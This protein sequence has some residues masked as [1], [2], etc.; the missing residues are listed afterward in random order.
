M[1]YIPFL[2]ICRNM[3]DELKQ[4][5]LN[6]KTLSDLAE[7]LDV[8]TGH[9][10]YW[11]N[12]QK[13][14][15][16]YTKF[17]IPKK[18]GKYRTI[19][20]PKKSLKLLQKKLNNI[21]MLF[22]DVKKPVHG[23]VKNKSIITNANYHLNK[24]LVLNLDLENFFPTINKGRVFGIFRNKPFEFSILVSK[25]LS[26]I[27]CLQNITPQGAPTSPIISNFVC[28]KLDNDLTQLAKAF[29]C[30]YSR[31]ADDITFSTNQKEFPKEIAEIIYDEDTKEIKHIIGNVLKR[32]IIMNGFSINDKKTRIQYKNNRQSVTGIIINEK[33]NIPRQYIRNTKSMLYNWEINKKKN[34]QLSS[35]EI[36]DIALKYHL[37]KNKDKLFIDSKKNNFK[38]TLRGRIN[39]IKDVRGAND[40]VYA[41]LMNKFN[42]LDENGARHIPENYQEV[43]KDNLWIIESD[44]KQG[45]AFLLKNVGFITCYHCVFGNNDK[46]MNNLKVFQNATNTYEIEVL[47]SNKHIDIVVFRLKNKNIDF[48][49]KGFSMGNSQN[50]VVGSILKLAGFPERGG[51]YEP[52]IRDMKVTRT[53]PISLVEHICVDTP[54]IT[55]HSGGPIFNKRNEVVGIATRGS[56]YK[57]SDKT[58]NNA[59]IKINM[60]EK[61]M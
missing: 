6:I 28:R 51:E 12:I 57:D 19:F 27:C 33:P 16:K 24:R 11:L 60:I 5:F 20:A 9:L 22:Y 15:E 46:L 45:T 38:S 43:I 14:N 52:D 23:F 37:A 42:K 59:F 56:S 48:S 53:K 31:Y 50:I 30:S 26:N 21:L 41:K 34:P 1:N 32:Y 35:D 29:H 36:M 7:V 44:S 25:I 39:F 18:N 2:Y 55:G 13:D 10:Y 4:K 58:T 47:K 3:N 8:K 17:D 61:Y 49:S 54:I 40:F